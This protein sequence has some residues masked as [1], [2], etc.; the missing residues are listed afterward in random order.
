MA[1]DFDLQGP[2]SHQASLSSPFTTELRVFILVVLS[3]GSARASIPSAAMLRSALLDH[4]FIGWLCDLQSAIGCGKGPLQSWLNRRRKLTYGL[5][6]NSVIKYVIWRGKCISTDES[7]KCSRNMHIDE[8][9]KIMLE[10]ACVYLSRHFLGS[11]HY[12]RYNNV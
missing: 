8:T 2:L 1:E 9:N 7:S 4:A 6:N 10:F 11:I 12:E 3:L 5:G